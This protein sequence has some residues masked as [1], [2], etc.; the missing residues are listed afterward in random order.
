MDT[1]MNKP[2]A[3]RIMDEENLDGLLAASFENVLYTSNLW[4][5]NFQ[6]LPHQTQCYVVVSRENVGLPRLASGTGEPANIWDTCPKDMPVYFFGKIFRYVS[7]TNPLNEREEYVRLHVLERE[8]FAGIVDAAVTAIEDAGLSKGRIAYDERSVFPDTFAALQARLPNAT[9]VPGYHIFRRIRAVK[10]EEEIRRLKGSLA[11]TEKAIHAAMSI[12]K[13]GVT[14]QEMVEEFDRTVVVGG[15]RPAFAQIALGRRGGQGNT[16]KRDYKLQPGDI[17]RFDVGCMY[18]GYMSDI[19][20]N[21]TLEEPDAETRRLF[22]A[23]LHGEEVATAALKP[24]A[25]ASEVFET[26]CAAI[27]EAG[28]PDYRRHH[29]GHGIGLETYDIPTLAPGD[30]TPIEV[31]MVFE[32]ETPYYTLGYAGLQPEDTVLVTESGGQFLNSISRNLEVW[33]S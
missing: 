19:A 28:I 18:E 10:T 17:I 23:V 20:R 26:A 13:I 29:V 25:T 2:R 33:R 11:L 12:A 15:G 8:P 14:E 22:A 9:F 6:V 1:L 30:H 4:N 5:E 7:K 21:F 24:G 27:R 16:M 3:Q 31:G 32:V